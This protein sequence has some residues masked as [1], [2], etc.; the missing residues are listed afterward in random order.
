M[1]RLF[2]TLEG[3]LLL[4][5]M[6]VHVLVDPVVGVKGIIVGPRRRLLKELAHTLGRLPLRGR[7]FA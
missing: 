7:N 6:R 3:T 5:L 4:N 1:E 2:E